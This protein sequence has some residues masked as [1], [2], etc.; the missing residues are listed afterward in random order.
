MKIFPNA[1]N[2][3]LIDNF[4]GDSYL[5]ICGEEFLSKNEFS[6]HYYNHYEKCLLCKKKSCHYIEHFL[7]NPIEYNEIT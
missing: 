6:D 1:I 5:C 4:D 3:E 2:G 7:V